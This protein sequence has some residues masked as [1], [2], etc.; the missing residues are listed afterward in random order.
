[1]FM[2]FEVQRV[3]QLLQEIKQVCKQVQ[4]NSED[5]TVLAA[6]KYATL[7]QS[8]TLVSAGIKVV[9]ENRIQD[10]QSRFPLL[11][12]CERHFIGTLQ[13]NKVKTAVKL[14]QMIES[15]DRLDLAKVIDEECDKL[16]KKMPVLI[17]I[18]VA[19]DPQKHGIR[20]SE[21]FEFV[22]EI[23]KY[24]HLE[25][26]GLMAIIPYFEDLEESRHYFRMMKSLFELC[27]K[28]FKGFQVLSMGMSHDF[29][30]AIEEGSTEVRIGRYFFE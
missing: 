5:I 19:K 2:S 25:I 29:K 16:G 12:P 26:R 22:K 27:R 11:L 8:N 14:F 17:E 7:D 20:P 30:V 18:N 21:T 23:S 3:H 28:Q 24:W 13:T 9:G 1:M 15:L 6:L 4:R 10:A